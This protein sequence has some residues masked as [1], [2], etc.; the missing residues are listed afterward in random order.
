VYAGKQLDDN[1][2]LGFYNIPDKGA[3][4][5]FVFSLFACPSKWCCGTLSIPT[6]PFGAVIGM[7]LF[8]ISLFF[9]SL[10]PPLGML[11]FLFIFSLSFLSYLCSQLWNYQYPYHPFR[12]VI[13][14]LLFCI[15]LSVFSYLCPQLWNSQDVIIGLCLN[16]FFIFFLS[17]LSFLYNPLYSP[18]MMLLSAYNPMNFSRYFLYC[19]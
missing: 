14:M 19:N 17:L 15:F 2:N 5:Y 18:F 4:V 7:L 13:G 1:T 9:L 10:H 8:F 11:L 6:T 3:V 16:Y 12:D